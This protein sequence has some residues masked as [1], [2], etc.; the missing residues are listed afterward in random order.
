MTLLPVAKNVN[1][2]VDLA[3]TNLKFDPTNQDKINGTVGIKTSLGSLT[4]DIEFENSPDGADIVPSS[5]KVNAPP[6]FILFKL[7]ENFDIHLK[8][9]GMSDG[10]KN[11]MKKTIKEKGSKKT[12]QK[13]GL[14][15]S[16][17]TQTL[18]VEIT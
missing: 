2:Q 14:H 8:N 3:N 6:Q 15:I 7:Q 18:D 13:V 17:T 10:I 11:Y 1:P 12:L 4:I 5:V 9:R 16:P